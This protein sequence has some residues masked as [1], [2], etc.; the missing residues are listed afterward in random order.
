MSKNEASLLKA[1]QKKPPLLLAKDRIKGSVGRGSENR[2]HKAGLVNKWALS[3]GCRLALGS[4]LGK[5]FLGAAG[6]DLLLPEL[7]EKLLIGFG[8]RQ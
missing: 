5:K 2:I 7:K 3:C 6:G 8:S 4:F 1:L